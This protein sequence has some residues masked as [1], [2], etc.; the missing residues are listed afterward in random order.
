MT[1]E[2]RA[3]RVLPLVIIA[4]CIVVGLV[5]AVPATAWF[6]FRHSYKTF[7][8]RHLEVTAFIDAVYSYF[9]DQGRW[10]DAATASSLSRLPAEWIYSDKTD[11]SDSMSAPLMCLHGPYHMSLTYYFEPPNGQ[12]INSEWIVSL[13][14]DKRQFEAAVE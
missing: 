3:T 1:Y 9:A 14:G 11:P 4:V 12:A 8:D 7:P 2:R 10:P 13:E 6:Q 5:L